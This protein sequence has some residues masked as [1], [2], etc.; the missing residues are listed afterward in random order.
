MDLNWVE[1]FRTLAETRSFSRAARLRSITQSA[2][3]K[4]IRSLEQVLGGE[5]I[6]RNRQPLELS[7]LG[8]QFLIDSEAVVASVSLA[9]RNAARML[10]IGENDIRFSAATTLAQ[11]F[12]PPWIAAKKALL[13]EMIP[14]MASSRTMEEDADALEGGAIDFFL[15]Y[16]RPD[17]PLP[18][19]PQ[20]FDHKVLGHE[21]LL[22][23]CAPAGDLSRPVFD[24]DRPDGRPIP[25]ISRLKG[26]YIGHLVD[27]HID[28]LK[29]AVHRD[30]EGA[31]GENI[32]GLLLHG[33]VIGWMPHDR[34]RE[35]L[36]QH[37]LIRAGG[38][39]WSIEVE[40]RLYRRASRD[41]RMIERLWSLIGEGGLEF[42]SRPIAEPEL[43]AHR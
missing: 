16:Y 25:Y 2:F 20:T 32:I 18:F 24:L 37:R 21:E 33:N 4:R 12:Y 17:H 3:S 11:S 14:Q 28:A 41:R 5:L 13:P 10:G 23:V 1:D 36:S 34:V 29:P 40:V 15:T 43:P 39:R 22:P 35:Y 7:P 6:L 9:R 19:D 31:N 27:A 30:Y 26:S 42:P 38:P 8:K